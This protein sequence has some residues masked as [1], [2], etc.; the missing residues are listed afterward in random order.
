MPCQTGEVEEA[1]A[2]AR[3]GDCPSNATVP[4]CLE[5]ANAL[6]RKSPAPSLT[7]QQQQQQHSSA[8]GN[9]AHTTN[10]A[11][12]QEEAVEGRR[13]GSKEACNEAMT[14]TSLKAP[15]SAGGL[16]MSFVTR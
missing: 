14:G 1:E 16:C 12:V 10:T 13:T 5:P 3:H 9:E 15:D 7:E 4:A 2:S 8:S 6:A 11:G